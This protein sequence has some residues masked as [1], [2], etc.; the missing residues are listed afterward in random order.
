MFEL[1]GS[2][3][4]LICVAAAG[5]SIVWYTVRNDI[6]PMPTSPKVKRVL[7][8]ALEQRTVRGRIFELGSGWGTLAF[9]LARRFPRCDV[10]AFENSPVPY[11]VSRWRQALFP[12]PNLSLR[13]TDFL[14]FSLSDADAVVC[15]LYPGGMARLREPFERELRP[16]TLVISNT[17]AVPGWTPEQVVQAADLYRTKVFVYRVGVFDHNCSG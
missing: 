14:R 7:L 5:V 10:L 13:R 11:M 6:S 12:R 16:G 17:F 9:A 3:L 8:D 15:Y 2:V 4:L 1:I